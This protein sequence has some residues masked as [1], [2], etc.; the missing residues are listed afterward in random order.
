MINQ[1]H[2]LILIISIIVGFI[3]TSF[4]LF[5]RERVRAKANVDFF[6]GMR[7][8]L[9]IRKIDWRE[10][11][12]QRETLITIVSLNPM[13]LKEYE[14]ERL[15]GLIHLHDSITDFAVDVLKIPEEDIIL[16]KE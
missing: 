15:E 2:I 13:G 14:I 12:K 1:P 9:L 7:A 16:F 6:A 4:F 8:L 10:F 3:S 5:M 11:K